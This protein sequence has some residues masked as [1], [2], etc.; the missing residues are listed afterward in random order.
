[1]TLSDLLFG[2]WALRIDILREMQDVYEQHARGDR[3]DIEALE[4]RLGG[5]LGGEQERD[6]KVVNGVAILPISGVLAPKANLMTMWCGGTSMQM[7]LA[8]LKDAGADRQVESVINLVDSPGGN[9][10]GPPEYGAA[11]AELGKVKP[12]VTLSDGVMASAAMWLGAAANQV[13]ITSSTTMVG[14][15]GVVGRHIDRSARN[16]ASGEVETEIVAGKY[17]RIASSNAPLSAE[18][19]AYLQAQV[20]YIYSVMVGDLARWRGVSEE[21]VLEHMAEGRDFVGQQAI[22]AGLV[23]G[24]IGMDE[25]IAD[26]S[27][28]PGR[29]ATRAKAKPKALVLP[30]PK[31]KP[32]AKPGASSEA[33]SSSTSETTK[34]PIMSDNAPG[35]PATTAI[36]REALERD[37][38]ALYAQLRTDFMKAGADAERARIQGVRA[39]SMPGHEALIETLA[40]DGTTQPGDAAIQVNA[41]QRKLLG[42]QAQAHF[43][44]APQAVKPGNVD[45][46]EAEKT[47]AVK[48]AEAKA[49]AAEHNV[50]FVTALKK[51]GHAE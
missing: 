49:Y 29:Y 24:I 38:G 5:K 15:L 17:K 48:V 51:L 44:D 46:N 8:A 9:V 23:D 42:T 20:D 11:L 33:L 25:L 12:V 30:P 35:A 14:N 10:I 3:I 37:H 16:K 36:T 50:D 28:N 39:Q 43:N 4:A 6:Y 21:Q 2:P 47:Q 34:D 45:G 19:L 27:K 7:A 22:D 31:G 1:M 40:F 18:G 13:Y 26:M 41:A 32:D